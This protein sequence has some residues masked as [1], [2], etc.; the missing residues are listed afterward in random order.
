VTDPYRVNVGQGSEELIH[1]QF[2]V[3]HRH[4]LFEFRVVSRGSVNGFGNVFE[5]EVEVDFILFGLS[6][7]ESKV[8]SRVKMKKGENVIFS[9]CH[10]S[11]RRMHVDR[12]R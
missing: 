6:E 5:Y 8:S 1:V 10:R 12:L 3:V 2:D 7:S 9:P 4:R 11:S